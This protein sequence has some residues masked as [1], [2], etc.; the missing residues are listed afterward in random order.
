MVHLHPAEKTKSESSFPNEIPIQP[1]YQPWKVQ[2]KER[3]RFHSDWSYVCR[4]AKEEGGGALMCSG[5]WITE[6]AIAGR[7]SPMVPPAS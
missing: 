3:E 6:T 2:S 4:K 5:L 7:C 1:A